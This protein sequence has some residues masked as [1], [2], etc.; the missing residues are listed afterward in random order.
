MLH[1]LELV[2]NKKILRALVAHAQSIAKIALQSDGAG[3]DLVK[4]IK[5]R[6]QHLIFIDS[7]NFPKQNK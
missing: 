6:N 5:V 3:I 7:K 4:D 2:I 1:F